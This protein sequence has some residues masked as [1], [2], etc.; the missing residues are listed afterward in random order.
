M[1]EN[2][3]KVAVI[4]TGALEAAGLG[5]VAYFLRKARQQIDHARFALENIDFSR[6]AKMLEDAGTRVDDIEKLMTDMRNALAWAEQAALDSAAEKE[7]FDAEEEKRKI[8]E[9]KKQH[10]IHQA[11]VTRKT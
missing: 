6:S 8:E 1:D 3:R 9:Q 4:H 5:E 2:S 11:R 7:E 10:G